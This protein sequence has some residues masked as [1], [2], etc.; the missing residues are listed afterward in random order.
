MFVSQAPARASTAWS[1]HSG[2]RQTYKVGGTSRYYEFLE[3][4]F[5]DAK[6]NACLATCRRDTPRR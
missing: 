6:L 2:Q 4:G 5:A 1:R 3:R